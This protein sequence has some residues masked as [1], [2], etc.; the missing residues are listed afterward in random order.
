MSSGVQTKQARV[1][2][3]RTGPAAQPEP[4][5]YPFAH[6]DAGELEEIY[7]PERPGPESQELFQFIRYRQ[8]NCREA[9]RRYMAELR[10]FDERQTGAGVI[11]VLPAKQYMALAC[12]QESAQ[13]ER[14]KCLPGTEK[15][16][17]GTTP[18]VD[19]SS[20]DP[21]APEPLQTFYDRINRPLVPG[22]SP[23]QLDA[24]S[25][26]QRLGSHADEFYTDL[27]ARMKKQLRKPTQAYLRAQCLK[28]GEKLRQEL[29]TSVVPESSDEG[30]SYE[31]PE[32]EGEDDPE[33]EP[34][35]SFIEMNAG[36][37]RTDLATL[38][39]RTI[40]R[41]N[42]FETP[43]VEKSLRELRRVID[44]NR[45]HSAEQS[46]EKGPERVSAGDKRSAVQEK[47]VRQQKP[48]EREVVSVPRQT[49]M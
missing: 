44:A 46:V 6:L 20:P 16:T 21:T 15:L 31:L 10:K 12:V 39:A 30:Y 45:A 11:D 28:S 41:G 27:L 5:F 2:P 9:Q 34:P 37:D 1:V 24:D 3:V 49:A 13:I 43:E 8:Q 7:R 19:A 18:V 29:L 42:G 32:D 38:Y 14:G 25:F 4:D 22:L 33:E 48:A 26:G 23:A 40:N 47:S 35:D 17:F 36:L